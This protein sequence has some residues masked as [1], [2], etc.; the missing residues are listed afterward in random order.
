MLNCH[1]V[2]RSLHTGP[3]KEEPTHHDRYVAFD[4]KQGEWF[5]L[6]R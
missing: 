4:T 6:V 5:H 1:V 3:L 2:L